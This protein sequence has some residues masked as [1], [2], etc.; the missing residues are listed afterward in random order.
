MAPQAGNG[1]SEPRVKH[2][3]G[4]ILSVCSKCVIISSSPCYSGR[5][6]G[7]VGGAWKGALRD[8]PVGLRLAGPNTKVRHLRD[9]EVSIKANLK[10]VRCKETTS[11]GYIK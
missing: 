11:R 7:G 3:S 5:R 6:F 8:V 9:H 1:T 2:A 10:N 4:I